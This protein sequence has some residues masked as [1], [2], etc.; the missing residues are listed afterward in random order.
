MENHNIENNGTE[1]GR[2]ERDSMPGERSFDSQKISSANQNQEAQIIWKDRKH[3]LWFPLSF[4][5][6]V[7][8]YNRLMIQRGFFNSRLDETLLYRIVDLSMNQ[9]LWGK[10]FGTG[11]ITVTTRVDTQP[12]IVLENIKHPMEVYETL[13]EVVENSRKKQ[14]VVGKE[15]YGSRRPES[16]HEHHDCCDEIHEYSGGTDFD[17]PDHDRSGEL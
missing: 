3:H 4:T 1:D 6:Y 11:N 5:K 17:G 10:L 2:E 7:V 8:K 15:F 12:I 13:S 16:F 14:N 9:T